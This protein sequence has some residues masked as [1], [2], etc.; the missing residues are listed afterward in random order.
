MRSSLQ[1]DGFDIPIIPLTLESATRL[2]RNDATGHT[3]C[4]DEDLV[5]SL[6]GSLKAAEALFPADRQTAGN[7]LI[8]SAVVESQMR[9]ARR[10]ID[11][12][13]EG[14]VATH[15]PVRPVTATSRDI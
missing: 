7:A 3:E 2:V 9:R 1:F 6:L 13:V 14:W 12:A 11:Q 8:W 10:D 15:K 4:V 5:A